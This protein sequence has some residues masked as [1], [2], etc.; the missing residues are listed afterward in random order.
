MTAVI[1]GIRHLDMS[2]PTIS[3]TETLLDQRAHGLFD[4]I[5]SAHQYVQLLAEVLSDVRN[6]LANEASYQ[7][8]VQFPRRLDA[9][10]LALYNLGKLQVHMKSSSRILNDLRS[11]RRLL[12]EERQATSNTVFCQKRDVGR[13]TEREFTQ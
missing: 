6:E 9:M 7:P 3:E 8:G 12:L 10:R 1:R 11:L 4:T 5:E 13:A 2:E